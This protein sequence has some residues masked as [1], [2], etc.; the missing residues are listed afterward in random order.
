MGVLKIIVSGGK[1]Q[2]GA[3]AKDVDGIYAAGDTLEELTRNLKEAITLFLK[4]NE[5]VPAVLTGVPEIELIFDVTG[6][7]KYYSG[8]ITF[9]A[10]E[11]LTGVNQKQLWQYANGHKNPRRET[12]ERIEKG[13]KRFARKLEREEIAV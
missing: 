1:E 7:V 5:N 10:M 2:Y 11:K 6:L 8:F 3:W 12:A 4:Y 13:L 9:P